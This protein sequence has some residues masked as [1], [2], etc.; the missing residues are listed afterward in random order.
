MQIY[1]LAK[2]ITEDHSMKYLFLAKFVIKDIIFILY[3]MITM[4]LIHYE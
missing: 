2:K 3:I 1:V 4:S